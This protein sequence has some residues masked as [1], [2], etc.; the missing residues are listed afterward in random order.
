MSSK[1]YLIRLPWPPRC[2]SPNSRK[3]RR[4]ATDSRRTYRDAGFWAAK[5]VL[6]Q[7][8]PD[9]HLDITFFPP[10][11]RRR[12]LDNMLSSIKAGLDGIAA[13]TCGDDSGWTL[14]I[15]K[16]QPSASG[17][18]IVHVKGAVNDKGVQP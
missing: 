6:A 5:E 3:D 4:A 15:S 13:A 16:G 11:K 2:L 8:Q 14:S 12:D 9:S 17:G 18:V 1:E 10:D 7:I